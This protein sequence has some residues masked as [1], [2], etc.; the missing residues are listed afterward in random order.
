MN[1]VPDLTTCQVRYCI[2]LCYVNGSDVF[3]MLMHSLHLWRLSTFVMER[4]PDKVARYL[5]RFGVASTTVGVG[6]FLEEK[7]A[8]SERATILLYVFP[9]SWSPLAHYNL[10]KTT[11]ALF[12]LMSIRSWTNRKWHLRPEQ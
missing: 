8:I 11:Q 10:L 6:C 4:L 1:A 5:A 9:S 7:L 2:H 12:T 3:F